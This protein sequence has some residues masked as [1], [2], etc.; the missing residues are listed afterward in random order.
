LWENYYQLRIK[1]E[2]IPKIV[3]NTRYGQYAI[4]GNAVQSDQ[5]SN[6]IFRPY[7]D[8]F[9]VVFIDDIL[10]YSNSLEDHIIYLKL[11]SEKLREHKLYTKFSK[12]ELWLDTAPFLGHV[13]LKVGIQVNPA[14]VEAIANWKQ[15][16]TVTEIRS[17]LG[18]ARYYY[19]F[20]QGFYTLESSMIRLLRKDVPFEW[21]EKCE[22][23]FQEFETDD[24]TST[25]LT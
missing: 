17:F 4:R 3:F 22:K 9:V 5:C 6:R 13:I 1:E 8:K 25:K 12:C 16:E 20:I 15:L 21:N 18:L 11:V 14:K 2:D 23:S 24:C 7:L 19:Q 10:I